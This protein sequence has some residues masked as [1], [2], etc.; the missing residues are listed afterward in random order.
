[1][2][3]ICVFALGIHDY[4]GFMQNSL[5]F[6]TEI[7]VVPVCKKSSIQ[8]SSSRIIAEYRFISALCVNID[9]TRQ[10]KKERS[11]SI[12]FALYHPALEPR[13][14]RSDCEWEWREKLR[15]FVNTNIKCWKCSEWQIFNGAIIYRQIMHSILIPSRFLLFIICASCVSFGGESGEFIVI[16]CLKFFTKPFSPMLCCSFPLFGP[17]LIR[18]EWEKYF[19]MTLR[20]CLE[21]FI[22][23]ISFYSAQVCLWFLSRRHV[24]YGSAFSGVDMRGE[25]WLSLGLNCCPS[26]AS[27][28]LIK[29]VGFCEIPFA[30]RV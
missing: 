26:Q 14:Q 17:G 24:E 18:D 29:S 4:V 3:A 28:N 27:G 9:T 25:L 7:A 12:I 6:T 19:I 5:R 1:M 10:Y 16:E 20:E 22:R 13:L 30:C 21:C 2:L 8:K 15:I 11:T 23:R